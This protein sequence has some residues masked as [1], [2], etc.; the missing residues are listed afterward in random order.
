M[1]MGT[2]GTFE[3]GDWLAVPKHLDQTH[4]WKIEFVYKDPE[5]NYPSNLS[6]TVICGRIETAIN[7]VYKKWPEAK[8]VKA[9]RGEA[10]GNK[11][12]IIAEE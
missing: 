6:I 12:V 11:G 1:I 3:M 9:F 4:C 7:E 2:G 8:I 10:W 5:K